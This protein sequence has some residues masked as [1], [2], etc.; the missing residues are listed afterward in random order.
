MSQR[1]AVTVLGSTGSIGVSALDVLSEHGERF[2]VFALTANTQLPLLAKQCAAFSPQFAVVMSEA[3]ADSLRQMLAELNVATEVLWGLNGLIDVAGAA[4]VSTVIAA[5]VG[6]AGLEPTMA[7]VTAGKKVLLA[8]KEALVMG[9]RLFTD[10]VKTH[11][12]LLLPV[13]S[14]HNAI[15]QCLPSGFSRLRDCGVRKI[16]LTGSGGPFRETPM[17]QL[18]AVTPAQAVAH[19]NW[20]MGKKISVDSSTMMNK[21]L[22]FIEACWLFDATPDD[23][24]VVIH[25]QSIIHSMVEYLDGSIVAQMGRPDMRTPLAHCLAWPERIHAKVEP[26]N[27]F[28]L[29]SLDFYPP[30]F[31][32]FPCLNMAIQAMSQSGSYPIALNAANEVAVEAFL[33]NTITYLQIAEVIAGVMDAWQGGEPD[34]LLAVKEADAQ[35]RR[36]A[37]S[38]IN[39]LKR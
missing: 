28:T 1:E 34:S 6:A 20:S 29:G 17:E 27:L 14:E 15:F 33:E 22:E 5:I 11:G 31:L 9:G 37:E 3:A 21:G 23:I 13:D 12:A 16:L 10:A 25:P 30:D 7:A 36:A 24:E 39:R 8:N 32:R 2:E 35:A 19:P 4:Q 26:L 18:A 38:E